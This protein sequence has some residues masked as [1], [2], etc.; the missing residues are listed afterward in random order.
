M[1]MKMLVMV[2]SKMLDT[3]IMHADYQ[4]E[5]LHGGTVG[6]VKLILGSAETDSGQE[7]PYKVVQ[8]VQKKW[9]RYADPGS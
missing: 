3:N 4:T 6:E 5:Q 7:V 8:K 9:E 1:N 2:L